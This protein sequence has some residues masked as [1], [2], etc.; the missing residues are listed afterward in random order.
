MDIQLG[1]RTLD[2]LKWIG[3]AFAAGFIGYF[4]RY[5]SMAIIDRSRKDKPASGESVVNP[6]E[7]TSIEHTVN[8]QDDK[9]AKLEIKRL[10]EQIKKAKKESKT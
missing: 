1:D 6:V 3:L 10:K 2:I 9:L 4:G 5:L 8:V 7:K